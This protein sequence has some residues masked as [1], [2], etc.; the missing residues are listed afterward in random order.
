MSNPPGASKAQVGAAYI[1]E[2][3]NSGDWPVGEAIPKEPELM[4][5][6]SVGR[7]TVREAV[8]SL[9]SLGILETQKGV[10]TFVRSRTPVP[11]VLVETYA[12]FDPGEILVFRRALEVEAARQATM[13]ATPEQ[14]DGLKASFEA[15]RA[16]KDGLLG[17]SYMGQGAPGHFHNVIFEMAGSG[18]LSLSY[19]AAMTVI[20]RGVRRGTIIQ[21]SPPGT[22]K[23]D[24]LNII[25][26]IESGDPER[27]ANV[28][29]EHIDHDLIPNPEEVQA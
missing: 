24:H 16:F 10:G 4:E 28:M 29:A 21:G 9:A 27:A 18:P 11:N 12:S 7:S 1:R 15:T 3:I 23:T 2:R 13:K 6:L 19:S 22:G 20:N 8:R 14:I 25:A 5:I 17:N 26:A